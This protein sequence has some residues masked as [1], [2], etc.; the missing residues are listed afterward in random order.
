MELSNA[1]AHNCQPNSRIMNRKLS[2]GKQE[3]SINKIKWH[4][5]CY[6][7]NNTV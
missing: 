4:D 7:S 6:Y 5:D 3:K 1:N 2:E